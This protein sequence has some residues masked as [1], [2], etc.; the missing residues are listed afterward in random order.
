[1]HDEQYYSF[2]RFTTFDDVAMD[3]LVMDES[4]SLLWC[5]FRAKVGTNFDL[6]ANHS[7]R[8]LLLYNDPLF[9]E[10]VLHE[11]CLLTILMIPQ[12]LFMTLFSLSCHP[13]K[14]ILIVKIHLVPQIL[15]TLLTCTPLLFFLCL[16][17]VSLFCG[18]T[19]FLESIAELVL[20]ED[21]ES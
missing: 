19:M 15:T 8:S 9:V 1:M 5:F 10:L 3:A 16:L 2:K 14:F 21:P 7:S 6:G 20:Y 18:N 13:M 4:S 12:Y 17:S 11:T